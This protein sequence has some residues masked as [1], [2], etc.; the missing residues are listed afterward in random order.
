NKNELKKLTGR[1]RYTLIFICIFIAFAYISCLVLLFNGKKSGVEIYTAFSGILGGLIGGLITLEGVRRT[2]YAQMDIESLKLIPNKVVH[3]NKLKRNIKLLETIKEDIAFDRSELN[4]YMNLKCD[5]NSDKMGH[6]LVDI[7]PSYK[8]I[9]ELTS[10]SIEDIEDTLV[11][12]VAEIDLQMYYKVSQTFKEFNEEFEILEEAVAS[13]SS[14]IYLP[15]Q[16]IRKNILELYDETIKIQEGQPTYMSAVSFVHYVQSGDIP[17]GQ[18]VNEIL[19][20]V[21]HLTVIANRLD[22]RISELKTMIDEKLEEFEK[23]GK[24]IL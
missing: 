5:I 10:T 20:T 24:Q 4:H 15:N 6:H 3:L 16:G 21:P 14:K 23:F 1:Q 17:P 12:T 8:R 19:K 11:K 13:V 18:I 9:T 2:V 7:I 22:K